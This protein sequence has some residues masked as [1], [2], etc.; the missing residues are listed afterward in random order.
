MR[1]FAP[2]PSPSRD[3]HAQ[4]I[5][6]NIMTRGR[7]RAISILFLS[8]KKFPL[9][10]NLGERVSPHSWGVSPGF[11]GGESCCATNTNHTGISVIRYPE[12]RDE[13]ET[14]LVTGF[15]LV[16]LTSRLTSSTIPFA[17]IK[18]NCTQDVGT[19]YQPHLATCLMPRH[20]AV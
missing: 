18:T 16:T 3:A 6:G 17:W 1:G 20:A 8:Y 7:A 15:W 4:G 19:L 12:R 2:P 9:G 13:N 10:E 11:S 5:S 14:V